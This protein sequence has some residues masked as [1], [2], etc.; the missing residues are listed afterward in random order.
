M[1]RR[2]C[3]PSGINRNTGV[4]NH[5]SVSQLTISTNCGLFFIKTLDLQ[6]VCRSH[7]PDL[8]TAHLPALFNSTFRSR[9]FSRHSEAW[10]PVARRFGLVAADPHQR[11]M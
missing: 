11:Q 9:A 6:N 8:L 2:F 5:R 4:Q 1:V 3:T 7:L 10:H